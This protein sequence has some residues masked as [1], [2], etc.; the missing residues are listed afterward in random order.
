MDRVL[1]AN[2]AI[3]KNDNNTEVT[4][5]RPDALR[6]IDV[7]L[8][9]ILRTSGIRNVMVAGV[10]TDICVWQT[11]LGLKRK[12]FKVYVVD[13]ATRPLT[14]GFRFQAS[15]VDREYR[16]VAQLQDTLQVAAPASSLPDS[17]SAAARQLYAN[18]AFR[19]R[20]TRDVIKLLIE[21]ATLAQQE[22]GKRRKPT[23]EAHWLSKAWVPPLVSP[24]LGGYLF[25][26]GARLAGQDYEKLG[27][28][29]ACFS[30]ECRKPYTTQLKD[31]GDARARFARVVDMGAPGR[32]SSA[33][34][35]EYEQK[36]LTT[37]QCIMA[38]SDLYMPFTTSMGPNLIL[39]FPASTRKDSN[40][41]GVNRVN[42]FDI[43]SLEEAKKYA[44]PGGSEK[45]RT[46]CLRRA[47]G[48]LQ[49]KVDFMTRRALAIVDLLL[50]NMQQYLYGF[51]NVYGKEGQKYQ[52]NDF[53]RRARIAD[54]RNGTA[55]VDPF[56]LTLTV[57]GIEKP[58][59]NLL[60][61]STECKDYYTVYEGLNELTAS[62]EHRGYSRPR[63]TL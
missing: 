45:E 29:E 54:A 34:L 35:S 40:P 3:F 42:V 62:V 55:W 24:P 18:I 58:A 30:F 32:P 38:V 26:K 22:I 20:G 61:S 8:T 9:Q 19:L 33:A 41:Y 6:P 59:M 25:A 44:S 15:E 56:W 28:R 52:V 49:A 2:S 11:C 14:D 39:Y 1:D 31:F 21:R 13:S 12:G 10:A 27:P 60:L 53:E 63:L 23:K 51:P 17:A 46:D 37:D 5:R 16:N 50:K 43:A 36:V 48:L 57:R 4:N 7:T 47:Q